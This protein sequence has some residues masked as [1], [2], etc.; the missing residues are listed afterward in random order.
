M[1][2]EDGYMVFYKDIIFENKKS[3]L[4]YELLVKD[5]ANIHLHLA[6]DQVIK[7]T[8]M[9]ELWNLSNK[10]KTLLPVYNLKMLD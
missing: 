8:D 3:F 9:L 5:N 2:V 4:I 7:E 6:K 1:K 10:D